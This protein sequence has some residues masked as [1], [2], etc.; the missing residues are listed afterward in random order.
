[1]ANLLGIDIGPTSVRG[2][3]VK[4]QL[5]RFQLA[6]YLEVPI[7]ADAMPLPEAAGDA[8]EAA[9]ATALEASSIAPAETVRSTP[10]G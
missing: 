10:L 7:E 6:Q 4:T 8:P 9:S 3:L 5:R 2:V 1:M